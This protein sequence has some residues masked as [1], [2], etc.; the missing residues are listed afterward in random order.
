MRAAISPRGA[1]DVIDT[2]REEIQGTTRLQD[3]LI[4]GLVTRSG[5]QQG[6]LNERALA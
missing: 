2:T 5:F 6:H 4:V 3:T 1:L